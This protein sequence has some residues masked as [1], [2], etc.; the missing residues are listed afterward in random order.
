M[1]ILFIQFIHGT[2]DGEK[3]E[4][5]LSLVF[6]VNE[7]ELICHVFYLST[8]CSHFHEKRKKRKENQTCSH[9]NDRSIV[10]ENEIF[11]PK[12]IINSSF[13]DILHGKTNDLDLHH[14][15][16]SHDKCPTGKQPIVRYF[17]HDK[18]SL[19]GMCV[20][21]SKHSI[22][23]L[24]TTTSV[25]IDDRDVNDEEMRIWLYWSYHYHCC[26][27]SIVNVH[28]SI[29]ENNLF[30]HCSHLDMHTQTHM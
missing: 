10:W 4:S 18:T 6:R 24:K 28:L 2:N 3:W 19:Q 23:S 22:I 15:S 12:K 26:D 9:L 16:I 25:Q 11:L 8:A 7:N 17:L 29:V 27:I 21:L 30:L 13:D 5:F 1:H 20:Y 14:R